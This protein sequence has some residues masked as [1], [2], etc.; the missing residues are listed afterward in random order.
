MN[1]PNSIARTNTAGTAYAAGTAAAAG[2]NSANS[3]TSATLAARA[4]K[5]KEVLRHQSLR[6]HALLQELF[7]RSE[8]RHWSEEELSTYARS[9]PEFAQ[10][11]AAARAIA[12]HEATVVEKTVTEIFAV[13][14]FMKHHPMAEVKAPRD[15][16]QV[17]VYATSAMLMNDSDWL[18]DRLLLWLKTILQAFIFPKRESSGQ[19]TL[20]GSRTASNNPAD[21]MAQRRQAIFETYLTLKRNYQQA[22]DPAQFSLIEP[23]LQQVVDT[24]SAD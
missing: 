19:K 9:V 24:L 12:R 13:Y 10:R 23:Y 4:E 6:R 11:A 14:A 21:N 22:L 3:V 18:R 5:V 8:G 1:T 20:F 2:A 16:S 15:I 17:S 7:R